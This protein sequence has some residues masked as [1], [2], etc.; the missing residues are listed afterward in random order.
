[1]RFTWDE[2]KRKANLRNHKLEFVDAFRAFQ[3]PTATYED[4]RFA[5]GEQR[6]ITLGLL[7]GIAVSIAHTES[8]DQIH[9]IS[10]RRATGHE[11]AFLF[12]SIEN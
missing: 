2:R 5:Y 7:D 4:D 3:G 1:M 12:Q 8:T 6:F 9:V 10:F 11:E